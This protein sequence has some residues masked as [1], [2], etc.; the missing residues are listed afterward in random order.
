MLFAPTAL[1]TFQRQFNHGPSSHPIHPGSYP[2]LGLSSYPFHPGS[3]PVL[4]PSSYPF[5]PGSNQRYNS[6]F[7]DHYLFIFSTICQRIFNKT[8]YSLKKMAPQNQ[9]KNKKASKNTLLAD[10]Y[11]LFI[12]YSNCLKANSYALEE[13]FILVSGL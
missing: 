10:N 6:F 11:L 13:M 1:G 4:G 5:N 2:V 8:A 12:N 9:S 3:F 7:I